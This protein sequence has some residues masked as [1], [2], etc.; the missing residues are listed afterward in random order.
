MG[1][2]VFLNVSGGGHVIATYGLVGEL[3]RRGE[4]I[5][6]YE[7]PHYRDD[8]EALGAEFRPTPP[9]ERYPGPLTGSRFHHELDLAPILTWWALEWIP[10]LIEPIRELDPDYIVHDSLSIWGRAIAHILNVPAI[11]SIHT[12]AFSWALA[13]RSG[14]YWRDMPSMFRMSF[15]TMQGFRAVERRLRA[16]YGL[17]R[18]TYMDTLTNRQPVNLCHTPRELQP[19]DHVFDDTYHFIGSVHTRPTQGRSAFP[20]DRVRE[21]LIYIGF[22]TIC[23]PGPAFFRNCL[24]AFGG[25][26][27]QVVMILSAS[28]SRADLG[29]IP[30]NF[31]V[32]S[33]AEDGMAPQLEI[34]PRASLFVMNGGMGGGREAAWYGIPML[35]VG[36][37]FETYTISERI[38]RQGAG[39]HLL[40]TV[41]AAALRAAAL[42]AMADPSYRE[43]SARIGDATRKA[44][45][46][47]RG[48]DLVLDH[49]RKQPVRKQ[50]RVAVPV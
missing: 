39:I 19:H 20:L 32:W 40:P 3:V 24:A 14:R 4:R 9:F 42:K 8:L 12:P 50:Q 36:T 6:Y 47:V 28:T 37:T 16:T 41:S 27:Y 7:A 2:G 43:N 15:R 48:A 26:D 10:K 29:A 11:C 31:I 18:T 5:V 21:P 22:G 25:L 35:A 46:A 17:R 38:A 44:G 23:D 13:L 34:L 49:V 45:G 1:T 33:L 30:D